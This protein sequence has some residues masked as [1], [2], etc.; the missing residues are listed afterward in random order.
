MKNKK[1]DTKVTLYQ[2]QNGSIEFR[3][4]EA[5]ETIW[6]TL[7]QIALL[8]GRDKSVILRHFRNVF[9]GKSWIGIQLLQKMQHLAL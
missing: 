1:I 2:G 6:A 7:D 4:D 5:R 3:A 8:F 9:S